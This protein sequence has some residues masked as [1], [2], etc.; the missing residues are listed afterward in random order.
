MGGRPAAAGLLAGQLLWPS[1][2]RTSDGASSA[3][4]A[5]A[6][7]MQRF[8]VS[9]MLL[10]AVIALEFGGGPLIISGTFM[11]LVASLF[12]IF[13]ILAAVVFHLQLINCSISRRTWRWPA[14]FLSWPSAGR[15]AD[16]WIATQGCFHA[17]VS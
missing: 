2:S 12:V 11:R 5:A 1:P 10:P 9:V 17:E 16:V 4:T 13:C 6:A 14:I 3:A 15:E 7:D 8:G